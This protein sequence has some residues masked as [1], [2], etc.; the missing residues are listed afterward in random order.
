MSRARTDG[1]EAIHL[2]LDGLHARPDHG[3]F[4]RAVV[5]RHHGR[6]P[7]E[8]LDFASLLSEL[9]CDGRLAA[10]AQVCLKAERPQCDECSDHDERRDDQARLTAVDA[11]TGAPVR[12]WA[13][14][15]IT[16]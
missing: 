4:G 7:G 14:A 15:P 16:G 1:P 8:A 3:A 5:Q 6:D 9:L 13:V 11:A 10:G 12:L 2:G